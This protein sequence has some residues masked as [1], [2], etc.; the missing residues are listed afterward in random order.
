[1]QLAIAAALRDLGDL[2]EAEAALREGLKLTP[3]SAAIL[4]QLGFLARARGDDDTALTWFEHAAQA[5][6]QDPVHLFE[7]AASMAELRRTAESDALMADIDAMPGAASN[8]KLQIRRL[9]HHCQMMQL[10]AALTCLNSFGSE[11]EWPARVVP[12]AAALYAARA[13]W[14]RGSPA[15]VHRAGCSE[16]WRTPRAGEPLFV[17]GCRTRCS[18]LG[19]GRWR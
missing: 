18:K 16:P 2:D 11:S 6:P 12:S 7:V 3:A 10:D 19:D 13:D 9:K 5:E 8:K 15:A 4:S 14:D 17:S 1:M